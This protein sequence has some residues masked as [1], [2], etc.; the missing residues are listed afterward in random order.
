MA[1]KKPSVKKTVGKSSPLAA[2]KATKK[3][4]K[5][6]TTSP[7]AQR[8]ASLKSKTPHNMLNEEPLVGKGVP[9]EAVPAIAK[10]VEKKTAKV[11]KSEQV[12]VP[13]RTGTAGGRPGGG[14]TGE[15]SPARDTAAGRGHGQK[16]TQ[17]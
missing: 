7:T 8:A 15:L 14:G 1:K 6:S 10:R 17:R 9:D 11:G 5:V 13:V 16:R 2:K 4:A 3:S 12:K